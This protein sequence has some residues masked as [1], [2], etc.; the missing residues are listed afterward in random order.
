MSGTDYTLDQTLASYWYCD[1]RCM[2]EY[3]TLGLIKVSPFMYNQNLPYFNTGKTAK[4][5]LTS[6]LNF[7]YSFYQITDNRLQ[8][9]LFKASGNDGN[10]YYHIFISTA[11]PLSLDFFDPTFANTQIPVGH[12]LL[13]N[14]GFMLGNLNTLILNYSSEK[15]VGDE[16]GPAFASKIGDILGFFEKIIQTTTTGTNTSFA[17]AELAF[18]DSQDADFGELPVVINDPEKIIDEIFTDNREIQYF[19][20]TYPDIMEEYNNNIFALVAL[21]LH[22]TVPYFATA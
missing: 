9:I 4:E 1:N 17:N 21:N 10:Y 16:T 13:L 6:A 7:L 12:L 8:A 5:L 18:F 3:P 2:P 19:C 14:S 22:G 20:N 11:S 15:W